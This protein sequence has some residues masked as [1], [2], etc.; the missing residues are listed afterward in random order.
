MWRRSRRERSEWAV[1]YRELISAV[2]SVRGN[3][4][5]VVVL[6]KDSLLET[7]LFVQAAFRHGLFTPYSN[8][9]SRIEN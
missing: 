9:C 7:L 1:T 8:R 4:T 2:L 5:N 6:F 3:D